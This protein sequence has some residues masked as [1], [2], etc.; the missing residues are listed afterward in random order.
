MA[1]TFIINS[2]NGEWYAHKDSGIVINDTKPY[3]T[4]EGKDKKGWDKTIYIRKFNVN[5]WKK[6]YGTE[7]PDS[8][9]IL[10]IGY[11]YHRNGKTTTPWEYEPPAEDWRKMMEEIKDE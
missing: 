6:Y 7:V 10:S 2:S 4:G 1:N 3:S 8:I 9:D 11:H 5:E